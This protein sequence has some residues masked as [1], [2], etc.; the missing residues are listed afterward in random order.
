[1]ECKKYKKNKY[2]CLVCAHVHVCVSMTIAQQYCLSSVAVE[3]VLESIALQPESK[4]MEAV[5]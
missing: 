2:V 1:M 3:H 4:S 5:L